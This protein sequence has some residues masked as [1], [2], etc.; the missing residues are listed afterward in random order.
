MLNV[1]VSVVCCSGIMIVRIVILERCEL[2]VIAI[3]LLSSS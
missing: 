1:Q 3:T 2:F